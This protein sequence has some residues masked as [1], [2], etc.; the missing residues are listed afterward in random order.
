MT[1]VILLLR[2]RLLACLFSMET[3]NLLFM[4]ETVRFS[5]DRMGW[6][7]SNKQKDSS[8]DVGILS[9]YLK[10]I[11]TLWRSFP[12]KNRFLPPLQ[13]ASLSPYSLVVQIA[14]LLDLHCMTFCFHKRSYA[15][16]V[17]T[18]HFNKCIV[19]QIW[20]VSILWVVKVFESGEAD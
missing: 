8:F 20:K 5:W 17:E 13:A 11:F 1:Y 6:Q 7:G 4:F 10:N 2:N 12:R 16:I 15:I 19:V 14:K 9:Y 3:E 18:Y